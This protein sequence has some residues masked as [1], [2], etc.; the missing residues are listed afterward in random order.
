[1]P[2][3]SSKLGKVVL[4]IFEVVVR[5]ARRI[6]RRAGVGLVGLGEQ[7][8]GGEQAGGKGRGAD[9]ATQNG[10]TTGSDHVHLLP[11]RFSSS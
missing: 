4:Q 6:D 10:P 8:G 9:A 11:R 3:F 7:G 5:E 1:M 2:V